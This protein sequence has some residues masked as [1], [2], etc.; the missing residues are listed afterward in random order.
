MANR[1]IKISR[2][3]NAV[4]DNRFS[5]RIYEFLDTLV[6]F[7]FGLESSLSTLQTQ[8]D[9]LPTSSGTDYQDQIDALVAEDVLINAALVDLAAE[10]ESINA[11][12]VSLNSEVNVL[13]SNDNFNR[14]FMMMGA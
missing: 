5:L 14:N 9:N 13:Q 7:V 11:S 2:T 4:K 3:E 12:L 8:V 10:D 1:P 6:D